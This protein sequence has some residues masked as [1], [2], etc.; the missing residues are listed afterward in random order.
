MNFDFAPTAIPARDACGIQRK[1]CVPSN[2][3]WLER[4]LS[5]TRGTWDRP[6]EPI[7]IG[8]LLG[9]DFHPVVIVPHVGQLRA[10]PQLAIS[11]Y[12]IVRPFLRCF[13][14]QVGVDRP[15]QERQCRGT[16]ESAETVGTP[17][18]SSER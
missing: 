8:S 17:C 9:V 2:R 5:C 16:V 1:G 15:A 4:A 3:P 10:G 18:D 11:K 12:V 7:V 6:S 13:M 14:Q